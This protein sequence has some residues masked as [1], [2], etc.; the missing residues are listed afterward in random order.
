MHRQKLRYIYIYIYMRIYLYAVRE[1]E[2]NE[3]EDA[4]AET[5]FLR[6]PESGFLVFTKLP[7]TLKLTLVEHASGNSR[8]FKCVSVPKVERVIEDPSQIR[9]GCGTNYRRLQ[10]N[11]VIMCIGCGRE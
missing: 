11:A 4:A 6:K 2:K 10:L 7:F 3:R 8:K 5:D 1:R 9:L